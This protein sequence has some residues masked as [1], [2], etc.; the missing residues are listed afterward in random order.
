MSGRCA[1]EQLP[2]ALVDHAGHLETPVTLEVADGFLG[3]RPEKAVDA[4][5]LRLEAVVL[6]PLLRVLD[7]LALVELLE[8]WMI[9]GRFVVVLTHAP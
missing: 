4:V 5:V 7:P 8:S 3:H 1:L 2:G 6:Q 9:A